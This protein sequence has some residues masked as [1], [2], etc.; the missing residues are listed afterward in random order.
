M[1]RGRGAS[2]HCVVVG[3]DRVRDWGGQRERNS[4]EE[5]ENREDRGRGRARGRKG[6]G[7][8]ETETERISR[9]QGGRGAGRKGEVRKKRGGRGW[10]RRHELGAEER[11][12]RTVSGRGKEQKG[13]GPT[14]H[15]P[16]YDR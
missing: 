9:E 7:S 6:E 3:E 2:S 8:K 12:E 10:V 5:E 13:R 4:I 14:V 16:P 11:T 1:A 15:S